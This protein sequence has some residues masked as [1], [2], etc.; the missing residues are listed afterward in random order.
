MTDDKT[1][2]THS[3]AEEISEYFELDSRRYDKIIRED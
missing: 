3:Q 1:N 2:T